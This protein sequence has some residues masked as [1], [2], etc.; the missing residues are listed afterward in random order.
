MDG[1]DFYP[2]GF[3]NRKSW[4]G[5]NKHELNI[6]SQ[7]M[8]DFFTSHVKTPILLLQFEKIKNTVILCNKKLC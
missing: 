1:Y 8:G 2:S 4:Q 3:S 7:T 5:D 6:Q